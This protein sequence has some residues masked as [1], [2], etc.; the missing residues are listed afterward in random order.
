MNEG[1]VVH[2]AKLRAKNKPPSLML[3]QD[4]IH[5]FI[6]PHD[7]LTLISIAVCKQTVILVIQE[8]AALIAAF[9]ALCG[10]MCMWPLMYYAWTRFQPAT[11]ARA[12][13]LVFAHPDD[14][15][16]F[17]VPTLLSLA[18]QG[19]SLHFMCLSTGNFDGLGA[20]RQRELA[21]AG[22][23]LGVAPDRIW[24]VDDPRLQ[25]GMAN[26]WSEDVVADYVRQAVQR[27]GID[28]LLTFDAGGISGHPN[29]VDT[30]RGVLRYLQTAAA[31]QT[32]GK[33]GSS[34]GAVA[35]S[36]DGLQCSR[37]WQLVTTGLARK[38][39]SAADLLI[40]SLCLRRGQRLFL[41]PSVFRGVA[42]MGRHAS[43]WVWFRRLFVAFS[44][45]TFINHVEE[46]LPS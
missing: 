27:F 31:S 1:V 45:Y 25:D 32:S 42:A 13:L 5:C 22:R 40:T 17:F 6:A 28:L 41:N 12:V 9:L 15:S 26:K 14:E 44:R 30:H 16:M 24:T 10:A 7:V 33:G 35:A 23:L 39:L 29:H 37:A 43:Q 19:A 11:G 2:S 21:A 46:M 36:G 20:V 3:Q 4:V 8:M 38:Y 34:S 18:D